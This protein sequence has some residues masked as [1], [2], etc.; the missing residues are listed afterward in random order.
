MKSYNLK[1]ESHMSWNAP[2]MAAGTLPHALHYICCSKSILGGHADPPQ[3]KKHNPS[4][5]GCYRNILRYRHH[6]FHLFVF[7]S[8]DD[9][10]WRS[11]Q[12]KWT[13]AKKKKT[14]RKKKNPIARP[15]VNA[16][17]AHAPALRVSFYHPL[18]CRGMSSFK[19]IISRGQRQGCQPVTPNTYPLFFLLLSETHIHP[20]ISHLAPTRFIAIS[21]SAGCSNVAA[22]RHSRV[23]AQ[24]SYLVTRLS[25]CLFAEASPGQ[26]S[27][28]PEVVINRVK[29]SMW[30]E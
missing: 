23:K 7:C 12:L 5:F 25:L 17:A 14:T 24:R 21:C 19:D 3:N 16:H 26:V 22:L 8:D 27:R 6:H 15:V 2:C 18:T 13:L 30:A 29:W 28:P 20:P 11:A 10:F 4:Y 9:G 1:H